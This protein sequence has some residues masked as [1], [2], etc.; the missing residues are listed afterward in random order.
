[1]GVLSLLALAWGVLMA[2]AMAGLAQRMT[3]PARLTFAVAL[4][5]KW[6][7]EPADLGL[8]AQ[9][10]NFR[11]DDRSTSPGWRIRGENPNGPVVVLVH[12]WSSGRIGLLLKARHYLPH[13]G[14]VILYDQRGHGESTAKRAH[15]GGRERDDIAAVVEQAAGEA[16]GVVLAGSSYGAGIALDAAVRCARL[17]GRVRGVILEG[18]YRLPMEPI[19]RMLRRARWPAQPLCTLTALA[20]FPWHRHG[21]G[22]DR[23]KLARRWAGPLLVLH[24]SDDEVCSVESGRAIAAAAAHGRIVEFP[25]GRHGG[26]YRHD[27]QRYAAALAD[28]FASLSGARTADRMTVLPSISSGAASREPDPAA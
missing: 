1:M 5:R 16:D 10:L 20:M 17:R 25:G 22:Y 12:G 4:A 6:T 11:F 21:W 23:V 13:A 7:T 14:A 28:F 8:T 3:R 24:G 2:L 18:P 15:L 9:E 26:L 27:P 19:E